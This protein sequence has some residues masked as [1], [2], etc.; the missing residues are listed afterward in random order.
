MQ[1][2]QN[3]SATTLNSALLP[4]TSRSPTLSGNRPSSAPIPTSTRSCFPIA[5]KRFLIDEELAVH[6][7]QRVENAVVPLLPHGKAPASEIARQLGVSQRTFARRLSEEGLLSPSS[8]T[9]SDPTSPIAIWPTETWPF[10]KLHGCLAIETSAPFRMP[11]SAGPASRP[12]RPAPNTQL[13]VTSCRG[14]SARAA[15]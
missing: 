8:W 5:R 6:S 9:V 10:R 1:N 7:D 14:Y 3:S 13:K 11:S 12:V 4:M 15:I 2:L